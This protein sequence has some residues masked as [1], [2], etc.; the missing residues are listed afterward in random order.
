LQLPVGEWWP[1]DVTGTFSAP[2]P[3]KKNYTNSFF[4]EIKTI[5][6]NK[7][8]KKKRQQQ[9]PKQPPQQLTQKETP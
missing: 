4:R 5:K 8:N 6:R 2:Q 1:W 7:K 3:E 9:Q